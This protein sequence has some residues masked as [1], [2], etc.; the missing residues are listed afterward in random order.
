MRLNW[1]TWLYGIF[2]ALIGG[3]AGS[4]VSV[5]GTS[6]VIPGS[7]GVS[8]NAGWNSLKLMGVTFVVHAA[9]AVFAFLQKSP[10]P[11]KVLEVTETKT[12]TVTI[13]PKD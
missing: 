11:E 9:I 4:V 2:A 3:G 8:G 12:E 7:V 1:E 6:I 5:I 13:K 10:L